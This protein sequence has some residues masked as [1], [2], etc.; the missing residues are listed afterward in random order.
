MSEKKWYDN[1]ISMGIMTRKYLHE[2]EKPEEFIPRLASIFS[3]EIKDDAYTLL[4]N[5]WFLPGGRTLFGAG[6]KGK[7]KLSTSNCYILNTPSDNIESIFDT[8]R[9]MARIFSYGG[10]CGLAI[11]NLRPK[12]SKVNNSALESTGAVSFLNV[13]DTVGSVIGQNG[14]R[15]AI[16]VGL[17]C[18]HPDIY[19]YLR[20]KQNNEK[21]ASMNI[22][23]K[24][25]DKFMEAVEENRD[26]ELHYESQETGKITNVINAG[27]FFD[28]FCRC[29]ADWGDPFQL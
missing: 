11:D 16:M 18:E 29:N 15:G 7:R 10:G 21:L 19:E 13:Y 2:G 17:T 22:S 5:A 12:G 1:E 25:T 20:V 26:F 6:Y 14:R 23:I 24:F 27:E 28:E 4:D 3:D 8:A 9:D